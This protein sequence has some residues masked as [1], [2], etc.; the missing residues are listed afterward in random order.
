MTVAARASATAA[1]ATA[2]PTVDPGFPTVFGR[3]LIGELPNF[4]HRP[5]LVVTMADLWPRFEHLFDSHLGAVHL[6]ETLDVRALE[7]AAAGLPPFA[8]VIGLGGGQASDVAKFFAWR[9]NRPL[10]QAPTAMT[11]NAPF[12][13]RAVLRDGGAGGG[14]RRFRCYPRGARPAQ[15]ERRRR[16]PLLSHGPLRLEAGP[17]HGQRGTPMAL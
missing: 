7:A 9:R 14:L 17:R 2:M 15:P 10:F 5:Y 13:H 1:R 12:S 16:R 8:S 4:V 6:V 11:T 3:E